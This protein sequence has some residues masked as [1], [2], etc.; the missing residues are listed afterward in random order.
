MD[1]LLLAS[2]LLLAAVLAVAAV[3]KLRDPAGTRGA[4]AGFQV[5][6]RYRHPVSVVLPI[7]E[8]GIA[9]LLLP[10][11]TA[12]AAALAAAALLAGFTGGLL[13]VLARGEEVECNCLGSISRRP[14][15][16]PAVL[17]NVGLLGLAGF[18]AVGGADEPGPS[19]TAWIGGLG[20]SEAIA[21]G[22][23]LALAISCAL[24]LAFSWQLM[25]QNGRLRAEL[26]RL[27]DAEGAPDEGASLGDPAPKFELPLL[28]G[29]R[30]S[31]EA[32]LAPGRGA[33]ILFS[34]P[35]CTACDPLLPAIGR[36]QGTDAA[37]PVVM[38]VDGDPEAV[39]A[40]AAEHGIE[41][42]LLADG[43]ELARSYGVPGIPAVVRI[44]ADGVIA[45]RTIGGTDSAEL[46]AGLDP[47]PSIE[48]VMAGGRA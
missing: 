24:N 16:W 20:A 18:V 4:L 2:R 21:L 6:A 14:V 11:A 48:I 36:I 34:D 3:A 23:A 43:F 17:R 22:I 45:E 39:S 9:V 26:A 28:G 1:G 13:S 33:T 40:K 5:P 15:G 42:V 37:G 44:G 38:I 29:G 25:K 12:E 10:A 27:S 19:A 46:L 41:P 31:L 47:S 30:L 7:V 35:R 8:I 32:L